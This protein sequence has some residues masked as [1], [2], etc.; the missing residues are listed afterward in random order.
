LIIRK[1]NA[2][3]IKALLHSFPG[4][5]SVLCTG[6]DGYTLLAMDNNNLIA[7]ASV[8]KREIPAPLKGKKE[9]FINVIDVV[10]TSYRNKGVGS[11]LIDEVKKIAYE[12]D[13]MQVRA[14]CDINN[15][16]SHALWLKNNFGISPV[17]NSDG[18]ILG[19]F[20]TYRL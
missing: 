16:A 20:V 19:S 6:V 13:S 3:D 17:K 4:V 5:K 15:E 12:T 8:C 11:A 2:Q 1:A 9:D 14:Y 7:F 10:E 18:T